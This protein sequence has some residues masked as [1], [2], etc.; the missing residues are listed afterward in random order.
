MWAARLEPPHTDKR[1]HSE[2]GTIIDVTA[3]AALLVRSFAKVRE[4]GKAPFSAFCATRVT[5]SNHDHADRYRYGRPRLRGGF[6]APHAGDGGSS[7]IGGGCGSPNA[8]SAAD[9]AP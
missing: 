9:M 8:A 3:P 1:R 4:L 5:R 2:K 7:G 6:T